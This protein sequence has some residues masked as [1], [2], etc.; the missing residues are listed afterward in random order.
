M[1]QLR[2]HLNFEVFSS[3]IKEQVNQLYELWVYELDSQR[4]GAMGMREYTDFVRGRHL[5]IDDLVVDE[6]HRSKK[7]GAL[8]LHFAEEEMK[9]RKLP[10][11]RLSCAIENVGG[12]KFYEKEKWVKRSIVYI[13]K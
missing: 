11:L 8:L 3:S 5:Y 9:K 13:K 12:M 1:K 2:P 6:A 4:I 10:S 7:I